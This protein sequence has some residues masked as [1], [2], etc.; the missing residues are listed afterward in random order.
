[1]EEQPLTAYGRPVG[2]LR[3]SGSDLRE[4]D[5]T[6]LADVA[7]Q[8]GGVVHAAAL[9]EE[10]TTARE[11]VV[12]AAEQERRR[13]RR[14]LHD[15]LGPSLAGLGFLTDRIGNRLAVGE[16]VEDDLD[17]LRDGLRSTVLD[18]RRVVEGLRPPAVDDLGLVHALAELAT[19]LVEP[20]GLELE[21]A[22][23]AAP[24]LVPGAV[25]AAIE[26]GAYR[27]AQEALTNVVRH[28]GAT[29]CRLEV[30]VDTSWLHLVV[31]D[32]GRGVDAAVPRGV[33]LA[34]MDER[35]R[36]IGGC[37]DLRTSRTG[38][39]VDVLLPLDQETTR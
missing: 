1:V 7:H 34:S 16:P 36:E 30:T 14:D 27:I 3:W 19:G 29:R 38:T 4:S 33:G 10:L 37:L 22:L 2:T 12:L 15:G 6:L 17:A 23:H 32:D 25:P 13:L 28:S 20:A 11:R 26:V 31:T 5:R 39:A 9:L 8:I 21:L 24:D 35:A 18:V